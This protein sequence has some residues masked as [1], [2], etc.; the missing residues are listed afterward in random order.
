MSEDDQTHPVSPPGCPQMA[1]LDP[2]LTGFSS[3]PCECAQNEMIMMRLCTR[4][5]IQSH[6]LKYTQW[7]ILREAEQP[8][9][10]R[11]AHEEVV[12][13]FSVESE[14]HII[15]MGLTFIPCPSVNPHSRPHCLLPFT[16]RTRQLLQPTVQPAQPN[17]EKDPCSKLSISSCPW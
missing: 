2:G 16:T 14:A 17:G 15:D 1:G 8:E 11:K 5:G 6:L 9:D 12:T 10:I 13:H 4:Q 7:I 3:P